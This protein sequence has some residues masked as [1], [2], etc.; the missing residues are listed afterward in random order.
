VTVVLPGGTLTAENT[1]L[2]GDRSTILPGVNGLVTL[3]G[4]LAPRAGVPIYLT[5]GSLVRD[6]TSTAM[7]D[8]N[9]W[10]T[11]VETLTYTFTTSQARY[12]NVT[13]ASGK[14]FLVNGDKTLNP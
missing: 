9:Y 3:Q 4:I 1:I 14:S 10:F 7:T 8:I 13:T 2:T 11:G 12:L 6:T 5:S